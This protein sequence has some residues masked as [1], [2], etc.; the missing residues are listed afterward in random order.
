Q[1]WQPSTDLSNATSAIQSFY[2]LY[3]AYF[4]IIS[5]SVASYT[6]ATGTWYFQQYANGKSIIAYSD[7]NVYFSDGINWYSTGT[8]WQTSTTL[9][10][11]T[12]AISSF[13]SQYPSYFGIVTGGVNTYTDASGTWYYQLYYN[14][15][16]IIAYTDGN[17]Y[18]SDGANWYNTGVTWQGSSGGNN[19]ARRPARAK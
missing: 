5:A 2:N 6:D 11:A 16:A 1:S 12:S 17:L 13:Y 14:G 18:F 15:T 7:G 4:G 10:A 19:K 3:P 9:S 8:S